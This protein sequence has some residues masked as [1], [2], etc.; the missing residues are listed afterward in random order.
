[1]LQ[2]VPTKVVCLTEVV[3]P[4]EL[5]DNEEYE[6]ILEDMRIE[7]QKFGK[8]FELAVFFSCFLVAHLYSKASYSN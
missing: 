5:N 6:D 7:G 2:P 1:M 4:D 8:I 3:N